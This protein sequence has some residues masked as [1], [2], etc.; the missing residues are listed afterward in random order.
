MDPCEA[1]AKS[2][3]NTDDPLSSYI[4]ETKAQY[5]CK[6]NSS[7]LWIFA[8]FDREKIPNFDF[9]SHNLFV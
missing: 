6:T 3:L 2:F 1:K 5:L 7:G 8:F 9:N 4:L